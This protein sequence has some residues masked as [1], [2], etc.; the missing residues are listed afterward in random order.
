VLG[1]T[2]TTPGFFGGKRREVE[3]HELASGRSGD[4]KMGLTCGRTLQASP[5]L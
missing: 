1:S 4:G 5:I 2:A 3:D